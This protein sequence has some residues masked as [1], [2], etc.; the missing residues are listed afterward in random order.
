MNATMDR[1]NWPLLLI[2]GVLVFGGAL[3]FGWWQLREIE[4]DKRELQKKREAEAATQT[5][6]DGPAA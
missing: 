1:S 2:E 3:L 4:R 5:D 6:G